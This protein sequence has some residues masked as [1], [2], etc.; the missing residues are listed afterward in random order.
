MPA[1]GIMTSPKRAGKACFSSPQFL[2]LSS[3]KKH[4]L[5]RPRVAVSYKMT[6]KHPIGGTTMKFAGAL[7]FLVSLTIISA[8]QTL[9]TTSAEPPDVSV[10]KFRWSKERI[11]WE[12]DPF[13]GPVENFDDMRVRTRNDRR[14]EVNKGSA[15]E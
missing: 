7:L 10:V 6:G 9:P 2:G 8:G 11:N 3:V 13:G 5:P 15:E 1:S 12:G 4:F 14:L